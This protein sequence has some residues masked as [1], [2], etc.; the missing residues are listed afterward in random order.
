MAQPT[1]D[2]YRAADPSGQWIPASNFSYRVDHQNKVLE[3]NALAVSRFEQ[4]DVP[5]LVKSM[6]ELS[7]K[8]GCEGHLIFYAIMMMQVYLNREGFKVQSAVA[9]DFSVINFF[10][11]QEIEA[12]LKRGV[13]YEHDVLKMSLPK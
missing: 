6:T 12:D 1:G 4:K 3:V 13:F 10:E 7:I 9:D 2:F 5:A 11:A 8:E